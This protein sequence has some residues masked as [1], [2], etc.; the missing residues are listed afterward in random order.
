MSS[1]VSLFSSLLSLFYR[2]MSGN[3]FIHKF[4]SAHVPFRLSL[5]YRHVSCAILSYQYGCISSPTAITR[6]RPHSALRVH[7]EWGVE[8]TRV[9]HSTSLSFHH[10][11]I[12]VCSEARGQKIFPDAANVPSHHNGELCASAAHTLMHWAPC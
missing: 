3:I 2:K 1:P 6:A 5:R 9:C 10:S 11:P 12:K 7:Q 8:G 4:S